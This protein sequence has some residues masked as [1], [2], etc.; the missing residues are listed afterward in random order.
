MKVVKPQ[1]LGVL[2]RVFEHG[3]DT[4]FAL[5]GVV[6]FDTRDGRALPEVALWT[7]AP[8]ELGRDAVLDAA[9][10]KSR[11]EVLVCGRAYPRNPPQ[12]ACTVRLRLGAVDKSLLVVGDRV[13][14]EGGMTAPVPFAEMPVTWERAYGGEGFAHNPL[15]R[16]YG[17]D[18]A[19]NE[20]ALPNVEHPTRRI[21]SP[22]DRPAPAGFGALD[23][24]WPQRFSKV[25]TYDARWL[26]ERYPGLA[27]DIDWTL[28]NAAPDD[29]WIEGF[30][31]GDERFTAENLHPDHGVLEGVLP[32]LRLRA[33]VTLR[34]AGPDGTS[35]EDFVELPMRADTVWLFPH[36]ERGALLYR[37]TTRVAEDDA[38]D[39]LHLVLGAERLADAPRDASYYADVLAR[40]LDRTKAHLYVLRD[41]ELMPPDEGVPRRDAGD[42][43]DMAALMAREGL[44][45][46]RLHGRAQ[47]RLDETRARIAEAGLDPTAAGL[48]E[49]VPP[50]EP[51][52]DLSKVAAIVETADAQAERAKQSM[53]SQRALAK[54][55][56]EA[57]CAEH[58]LDADV[59][60]KRN[61]ESGGPPR[62][63]ADGELAALR[64]TALRADGRSVIDGKRVDAAD[65]QTFAKHSPIDNRLLKLRG[66]KDA[67]SRLVLRAIKP[68]APYEVSAESLP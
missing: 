61:E 48:P 68:P 18:G 57:L 14:R 65:G 7:F 13:W 30:F 52:P 36:A 54:Q 20:R 10:P 53:A 49:K 67:S 42:G 12:A 35:R 17:P 60:R 51:P 27:D 64:A 56:F 22:H 3:A 6:F 26:R 38:D 59:I 5:T 2:Q 55:R 47:R 29:Q 8:Q 63:S 1:R 45:E 50:P 21:V 37:G 11:G 24:S 4:W 23:F 16:G 28:F 19:T 33:F 40:R 62:F 41:D 39:V 43:S 31:T 32:G 44:L 25:G 58:G 9:M 66:V 15:G 34:R 46:R